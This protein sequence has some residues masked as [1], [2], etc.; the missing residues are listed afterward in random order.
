MTALMRLN[1]GS[2]KVAEDWGRS[3]AD[4]ANFLKPST[5]GLE[6]W[7]VSKSVV[8][9]RNNTRERHKKN[10]REE[11]SEE[12]MLA[13]V[14]CLFALSAI[15]GVSCRLRPGLGRASLF[16]ILQPLGCRRVSKPGM[17]NPPKLESLWTSTATYRKQQHVRLTRTIVRNVLDV[18]SVQRRRAD[19]RLRGGSV[20]ETGWWRQW[21]AC[22]FPKA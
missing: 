12:E 20:S 3:W 22:S 21:G 18:L 5:D 4:G 6:S 15:G 16:M 1:Q 13:V 2:L 17:N 7:C 8:G 10:G 11:K 14:D 9:R 19:F